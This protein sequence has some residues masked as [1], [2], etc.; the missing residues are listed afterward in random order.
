[1]STN[2]PKPDTPESDPHTSLDALETFVHDDRSPSRNGDSLKIPS[3]T[4]FLN[5]GCNTTRRKVL[6][7]FHRL[8]ESTERCQKYVSCGEGAWIVESLT[9]PGKYAVHAKRCRD[10]FCPRCARN[11]SATIRQNLEPLIENQTV[12]LITL[13]LKATE[14]NLSQRIS[15]LYKGFAKLRKHP[16]WR[17]NVEAAV[18]FLEVTR[19]R[20]G[21]HWHTHVHVVAIGKYVQHSQLKAA[22]MYATGDSYI[23]DV[24]ACKSPEQLTKYV[25]KYVTKGIDPAI[26]RSP[27][28]TDE[29]IDS[30]KGVRMV[31]TLGAWRG[32]PLLTYV[33]TDEWRR[34]MPWP[35][36]VEGC[37]RN[38]WFCVSLY[39]AIRDEP[40]ICQDTTCPDDLPQPRG[41]PPTAIDQMRA[42]HEATLAQG[43]LV[44]PYA[45]GLNT[46][47]EVRQRLEAIKESTTDYGRA[48]DPT[49]S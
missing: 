38:D 34:V 31:T 17:H 18:A 48:T 2:V 45:L 19:G 39:Y 29:V 16:V 13:T 43:E 8:G 24:R 14:D 25:T 37:K 30:L 11:R 12:R 47:D 46:Y 40:Y 10:R 42:T 41:S 4:T 22:W 23:V 36:F 3:S 35:E 27:E 33:G 49:A 32:Q 5:S 20:L 28:L 1:M 7:A 26:M 15:R 6:A 9:E 44:H 21:L